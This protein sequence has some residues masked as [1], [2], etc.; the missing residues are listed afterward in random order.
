MDF[1][2]PAPLL[3]AV[4]FVLLLACLV[5]YFKFSALQKKS[6]TE[7]ETITETALQFQ[8]LKQRH[9]DVSG[10][11]VEQKQQLLLTQQQLKSEQAELSQLQQDYARLETELKQERQSSEEKLQLLDEAKDKLRLEFQHLAQRIF[12]EKGEKFQRNQQEALA[13]TLNP[14][15]EQLQSFRHKVEEVY[16]KESKERISLLSEIGHLKNLNQQ[17]S[18]DAINLT[19][20]LKGDNKTQGNWG[21]VILEKVLEQSGLRKGREYDVQSSEKDADGRRLIPDVIVHLPNG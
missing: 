15:R 12:E 19:R 5:F 6:D 7:R 4:T 20:A 8:L 10:D 14:L 17:I 2:A 1:S 3:T 9:T 21:E 18:Q 11:L 16:D 13:S